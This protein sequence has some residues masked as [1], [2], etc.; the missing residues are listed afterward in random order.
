MCVVVDWI[1]L[2]WNVGHWW[3]IV[4]QQRAFWIYERHGVSWPAEQPTTSQDRPCR[5][6]LIKILSQFILG[7]NSVFVHYV[8]QRVS[9]CVTLLLQ[10]TL[11]HE[12]S[13]ISITV[14]LEVIAVTSW[15]GGQ[16][17]GGLLMH[18]T[19]RDSNPRVLNAI[20]DA[21]GLLRSVKQTAW[22]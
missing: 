13:K 14:C 11:L 12:F 17:I 5:M 6:E 15:E 4:K 1:N 21:C 20:R 16:F 9:N 22:N 10:K 8:F 3:V 18:S 7:G 2:I 19:Q